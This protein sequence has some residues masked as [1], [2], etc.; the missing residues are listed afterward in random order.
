MK[1]PK[2]RSSG[3][4]PPVRNRWRL[5]EAKAQ[6]SK[7][8]RDAQ[9]HG[10][11]RVTVHGRDAAVIV[12]AAEFDRMQQPVSG[13][14]IVRALADSPLRDVPFERLSVKSPVRDIAV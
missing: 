2:S 14:D 3:L 8:V 5:Q 9:T 12:S 4:R 11:Q 6:L 13:R 10:P 7:V 1:T